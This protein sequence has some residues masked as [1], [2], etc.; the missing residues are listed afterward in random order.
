LAPTCNRPRAPDDTSC[1]AT[2]TS[3]PFQPPC[4]NRSTAAMCRTSLASALQ[5]SW[6]HLGDPTAPGW[7]LI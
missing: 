3:M 6:T 4:S 2:L 5:Q 1:S 7:A